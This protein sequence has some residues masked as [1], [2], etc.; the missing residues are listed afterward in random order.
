MMNWTPL[1]HEAL[2]QG[3][4]V[5]IDS[6]KVAT[7]DLFFA[8]KGDRFNA[9]DFVEEVLTKAPS[10][11]VMDEDRG[12]KDSRIIIVDDALTALQDFARYHRQQ[13][14]IPVIGLTGSNGKTTSKELF[15]AVLS[16]KYKVSSTVGNLNNHI[17]VPL[18]ILGIRPDHEIA[19]VEMGANAQ[20][21]IAFLCSVSQP[22]I[23]YITNFGLAHLEGFGGPEGVVKG[24]SELYDYLRA[25]HKRA[26]VFADAPRQIEKS[27]GI[28]RTLF[29][30]QASAPYQFTS[31]AELP[32]FQLTYEG[33]SIQTQL[34]GGY[35]FSNVAAA[36]T[37]GLLFNVPLEQI[38]EGIEKYQPT[39]NRSQKQQTDRNALIIDCYN[40]NPSSMELALRSL[41]LHPGQRMAILGDMF[42]MGEYEKE[43]HQRI[44][45]LAQ[46]LG[47]E[48][49][50]FVG[51][52][53]YE[54]AD[55]RET[56]VRTT[57]EAMAY[58]KANPPHDCTILLK[59]SRGMTLE[60][61]IPLL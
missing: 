25:H 36:I 17:G 18:T 43:E 50:L 55:S 34:S 57:D 12:L 10:W 33:R 5:R 35:N 49:R 26:I 59:G 44:A 52:A 31:G 41:S 45:E 30:S 8:L 22:D 51:D 9:N 4:Q 20:K 56:R 53:F 42:E 11:V 28:E 40:A 24:K 39:N 37:M 46:T 32:Y 38:V 1:L 13:L 16:Q 19:V 58:L 15:H 14:K 48:N 54:H 29:G 61:L 7:G 3:G 47:I 6:R 23:G 60:K 2:L 27:A 21:E